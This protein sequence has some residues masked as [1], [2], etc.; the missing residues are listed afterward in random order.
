MNKNKQTKSNFSLILEKRLRNG[1]K[2]ADTPIEKNN[3]PE[4]YRLSPIMTTPRR[5]PPKLK[6]SIQS[7]K[8]EQMKKR[9]LAMYSRYL[10]QLEEKEKLINT[11]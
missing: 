3:L 1:K 2:L 9:F 10:K 7:R 11:K 4:I 5:I 6:S 8:E